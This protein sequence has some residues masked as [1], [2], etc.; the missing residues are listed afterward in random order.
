MVCGGLETAAKVILCEN[1]VKNDHSDYT[2]IKPVDSKTNKR[3]FS[4]KVRFSGSD[5]WFQRAR[6]RKP[7]QGFGIPSV[8]VLTNLLR[9]GGV[10]V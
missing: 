7:L 10:C 9:A 8:D 1:K 5:A 6:P 2:R 4:A 3:P